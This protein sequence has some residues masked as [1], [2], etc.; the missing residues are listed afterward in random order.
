MIIQPGF[1][2]DWVMLERERLQSLFD[3]E[4]ERLLEQLK[5]EQRWTCWE[6]PEFQLAAKS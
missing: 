4:V 1:Y 2:D 6:L 5:Y 3:R